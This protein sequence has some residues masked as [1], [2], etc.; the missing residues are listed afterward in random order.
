MHQI[1][2]TLHVKKHPANY[3]ADTGVG[4]FQNLLKPY[5][6]HDELGYQAER[7]LDTAFLNLIIHDTTYHIHY[8]IRLDYRWYN[9]HEHT[10]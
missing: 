8:P 5:L 9:I 10:D 4:I 1:H 3:R 2:L 7:T 6:P